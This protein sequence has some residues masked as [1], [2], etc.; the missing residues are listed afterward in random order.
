MVLE[1]FAGPMMF[2][3]WRTA[4]AISALN[5]IAL[6]VGIHSEEQALHRAEDHRVRSITRPHQSSKV[7]RRLKWG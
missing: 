4:L 2:G 3:A 1:L 6:A 7:D 5:A